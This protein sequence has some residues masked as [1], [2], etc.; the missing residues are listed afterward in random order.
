MAVHDALAVDV[1]ARQFELELRPRGIG[2]AVLGLPRLVKDT[3][4]NGT[5]PHSIVI[6]S[7]VMVTVSVAAL[8][9]PA[10]SDG[11][12]QLLIHPCIR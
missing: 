8:G 3:G 4:G 9:S 7:Y 5:A 6:S 11:P 2:P 12:S 1:S 10:L